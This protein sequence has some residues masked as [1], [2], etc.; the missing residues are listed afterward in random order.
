LLGFNEAE[1][2]AFNAALADMRYKNFHEGVLNSMLMDESRAPM[3]RQG[4]SLKYTPSRVVFPTTQD[5]ASVVSKLPE[6][7]LQELKKNLQE[8]KK[9]V[10][11]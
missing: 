1:A 7:D 11:P 9:L 10:R 5:V 4:S 8:L 2:R 3:E 6:A